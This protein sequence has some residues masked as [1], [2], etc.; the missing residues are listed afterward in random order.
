MHANRWTRRT[1]L[2][3]VA[4]SGLLGACGGGGSSSSD[5]P[6]G[7]EASD[8]E[9]RRGR[10]IYVASCALC[11]GTRGQGGIGPKLAD[12]RVVDRYPKI[13]DQLAV[14]TNGRGAM[15]PF[16]GAL[17]EADTRAVVRYEREGL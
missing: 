8:V 10:E 2:L 14:V 7:E 15:P 6:T 11:H 4:A 9:L 12:G 1:V 5:A 16:G 3:I 13:A 17:S